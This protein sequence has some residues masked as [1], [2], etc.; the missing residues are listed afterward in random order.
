[1]IPGNLLFTEVK[2]LCIVQ[3]FES[4]IKFFNPIVFILERLVKV[5]DYHEGSFQDFDGHCNAVS[6]VKFSPS[7][8]KLFS[9][10]F[11]DVVLWKVQI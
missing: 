11:S 3:N 4:E 1:M 6:A 9:V 5:L 2:E 8:E 7:G 10:G